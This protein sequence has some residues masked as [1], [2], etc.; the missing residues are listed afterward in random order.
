MC[1]LWLAAPH[2]NS[3]SGYVNVCRKM[4]IP[5]SGGADLWIVSYKHANGVL[6]FS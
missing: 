5:E 3:L 2:I 6:S 4:F 1:G